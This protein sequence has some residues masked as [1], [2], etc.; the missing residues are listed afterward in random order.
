[1]QGLHQ[2][3]DVLHMDFSKGKNKPGIDFSKGKNKPRSGN[4]T[5]LPT[6]SACCLKREMVTKI[7]AM[8]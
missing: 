2:A 3:G 8:Q 6:A 5:P 1:M 4:T 7:V